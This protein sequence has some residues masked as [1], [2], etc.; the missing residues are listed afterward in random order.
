MAEFATS[1]HIAPIAHHGICSHAGY[2]AGCFCSRCCSSL[3]CCAFPVSMDNSLDRT[4]S[5]TTSMFVRS[6]LITISTSRMNT[7]IIAFPA[8][9]CAGDANRSC[10]KQVC[11]WPCNALD[12]VL[13]R[14]TC[15]RDHWL[16]GGLR[17]IPDGYGYLYQA[18]ISIGSIVYGTLGFWL[19]YLSCRRLCSQIATISA[20]ILLWLSSNVLL[21][22][23]FSSRRC[24]TWF[25][26]SASRCCLLFGFCDFA[27]WKRQHWDKQ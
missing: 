20:I 17:V 18:A 19:A 13:P 8:A 21:L 16:H 11:D 6:S 10:A 22:S 7:P 2:L 9:T 26:C 1:V 25:R 5:T 23:W 12:A 15:A 4:A 27:K 3:H 14:R 24:R